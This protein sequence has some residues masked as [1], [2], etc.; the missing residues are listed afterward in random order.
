MNKWEYSTYNFF[1]DNFEGIKKD[2][3]NLFVPFFNREKVKMA[4]IQVYSLRLPIKKKDTIWELLNDDLSIKD[5]RELDKS[6]N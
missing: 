5:I 1:I 4:K 2:Y 3:D 6:S